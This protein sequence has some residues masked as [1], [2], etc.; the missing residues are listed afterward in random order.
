[1]VRVTKSREHEGFTVKE[2][3]SHEIFFSPPSELV[4]G[5]LYP[6]YL[7]T[8]HSGVE[9]IL[10]ECRNVDTKSLTRNIILVD[11]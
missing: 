4:L 11:P 7:T 10:L 3:S 9:C 2:T 8:P 1:M 5:P 6:L